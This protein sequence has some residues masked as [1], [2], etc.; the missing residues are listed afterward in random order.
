MKSINYVKSYLFSTVYHV[1]GFH[2][3]QQINTVGSRA[4]SLPK[5]VHSVP[6]NCLPQHSP[7]CLVTWLSTSNVAL[8]S[9]SEFAT[10]DII[11]VNMMGQCV[12]KI[13]TTAPKGLIKV[14]ISCWIMGIHVQSPI[15]PS[16]NVQDACN[17]A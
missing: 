3:S 6:L 4:A 10:V 5:N 11:E 2:D 7:V 13:F 15:Q 16:E 17:L 8:Y 9:S 12:I 14:I 1:D